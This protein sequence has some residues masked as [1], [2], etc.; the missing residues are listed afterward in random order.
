M[1]KKISGVDPFF[2]KAE[3]LASDYS[4][5]PK[6]G[7][8]DG[9]QSLDGVLSRRAIKSMLA[10]LRTLDVDAYIARTVLP[11]EDQARVGAIAVIQS[12]PGTIFRTIDNGPLYAVEM[13]LDCGARKRRIGILAQNRKANNGV[14]M[15]EHHAQAVEIIREFAN[16]SIPIVTLIDTPGADAGEVANA[17]N[18]AHS[19]SRLIAEMALIDPPT[20]GIVLGNGYSGGAIPLATTNVLL[21]VRDGVF[22]TI[23]PRGLASIARK[24]NVS[25]QECAKYVGV[26]AFELHKQGYIDGII[27]Y[28]PGEEEEKLDNLRLAIMSGIRSIEEGVIDFINQNDY[29]VDHYIRSIYR[30]L[31]PSE[32]LDHYQKQDLISL[33]DS[34][35]SQLNIYGA[36]YRYLRYLGLR[37]RLRSTTVERYGRLSKQAIPQ[38]DLTKRTE[39]EHREAFDQWLQSPLEIK[40]DDILGKSWKNFNY[41][42]NKLPNQRGKIRRFILG[43]PRANFRQSVRDLNICLCFHLYNLWKAGAQSNFYSLIAHLSNSRTRSPKIHKDITVLEVMFQ[44]EIKRKTLTECQNLI[45]FDLIYNNVI[46]NLTA[47]AQE[48]KDYNV[49]SRES[50]KKLMDESL[51][52]AVTDLLAALP[53]GQAPDGDAEGKLKEQFLTWFEHVCRH[54]QRRVFLKSVEEWKKIAFP[55]ISETLFAI[56]T[57]VFERLIPVYLE[58]ER[59]DKLYEGQIELRDIGMKDFW[60]RLTIAYHDLMI[61]DLLTGYKRS[62]RIMPKDI[63]SMFFSD[64]DES[65]GDL[66][67]ADPVQFPGF[68]ISIEQSLSKGIV[69]CGTVTGIAQLK[70]KSIRRKVGVVMSNLSFQAG[71]FDMASGEKFCKLLEKCARRHIPVV[72]FISSGGM[73]TKEGAGALFSMAIVN[74]RITRFVRDNDLPIIC[75][76]FGDCTG[77][78]QASMVTH[79]LVQSYYFSGTNMPFA[80]QIVVPSYLPTHSTLSNYLS[81]TPGAMQGL[82]EHPFIE[83][84]DEELRAI[85]P[86]I[87]VARE[88]VIDVM[89]RIL[90]GDLSVDDP[91]EL[92]ATQTVSHLSLMNPV[93]RVL[94]HARGCTAVKLIRGAHTAGVDIVLV[95]SDPDID[96]VAA[97]MLKDNDRLVCLGG[98]TSDESYLNARSVVRIAEREDADALHPGIGFLSENPD[99][100]AL[101]RNHQLNFIGPPVQ[102]MVLMGN[103]SNA[104][105]TAIDLKV[106]VVP[107]SHGIMTSAEAAEELSK[108]IGF[109]VVIKAVHGGGGKG[110]RIVDETEN[111]REIF[112]QMMAEAKSAFGNS[113]VYIEKCVTSL[114]HVEVQILR[115]RHSNTKV[116]GLRDCTVQRNNQKVIEESGS[117]MLPEKLMKDAFSYSAAIADRIGYIGA[118]TV[119]FIFDLENTSIYFMEMNTRLQVEHPVTETV[120]GIDIVKAQ[121][122]VAS[123]ASIEGMEAAPSGYAIEVRVNAEKLSW[124]SN[125]QVTLL[126]D[127]GEITAYTFPKKKHIQII[128]TV[129]KGKVV[130]SYYDSMIMQIVCSGSDRTDTIKKMLAYLD[131]VKIQGIC[132]NIPLLKRILAD[133]IF[134]KGDY[135]T[136]YL[137]KFLKRTDIR[138]LIEEIET[139]AGDTQEAMSVDS[140]R[141]ED[142]D[143]LKVIS[144]SSGIFYN[145]PSP[146]EPPFVAIGDVVTVDKTLCLIEA[147]KVFQ[148]IPLKIFNREELVIYSPEDRFEIVRINPANAQA[149]NKGDLLFVV[150]PVQRV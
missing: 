35:T 87:P 143:E 146:A 107:G 92:N 136:T 102:S 128:S 148:P 13:H 74:D 81:Q 105:N 46:G 73:Q 90:Q 30:F 22:N 16:H 127:P 53:E 133:D 8:L 42:K 150:R 1:P 129:A 101:C 47:I 140:L 89:T 55:R 116:L 132:T 97:G 68:R 25:W 130:P 17:H 71:A 149:V 134:V 100:A 23:Q 145:T 80:G 77:G 19:I 58:S 104:I 139:F 40:Y 111:F 83:T 84:L 138:S 27:D 9:G 110:I 11:A 131:T 112:H 109:P 64:F 18:Q 108:E 86:D 44:R 39:K 6:S 60:N 59:S 124:D 99:F 54:P 142:S 78:A 88:S 135:D 12:L 3:Q 56:V 93:K 66:M 14:W 75:F 57:F 79:P 141:I 91:D 96:S 5:F 43:D 119:E 106:S 118:G 52:R 137:P 144:S 85:D 123:G 61:Q 120:T 113:D 114:R 28:V 103:K 76:G 20:I 33:P 38:G 32:H 51:P 72:C 122:D 24:Y 70:T 67:T 26:S 49:I 37:N 7:K 21:S 121:F 95:Q 98:N 29:V 63:L 125:G 82:V 48:A 69:P 41:F 45:M 94:L 147:M 4:L 2:L 31:E 36:A 115:D 10:E 34:P 62:R 65:N 126:P 117:T 15:A 50:I